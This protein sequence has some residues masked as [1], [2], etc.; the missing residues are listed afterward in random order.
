MSHITFS[1]SSKLASKAAGH[2]LPANGL[3]KASALLGLALLQA[4]ASWA[5]TTTGEQ[6]D[7][8]ARSADAPSQTRFAVDRNHPTWAGAVVNYYY[9]PANQPAALGTDTILNLIQSATRKWQDVCNVTFN[10][11]G[12]TTSVPNIGGSFSDIDRRNVIGWTAFT[13][14]NAGFDGY[15]S[16]WYSGSPA[17]L[18][19]SDMQINTNVASKFVSNPANL[20]ALL[21]HEFGHM[22]AIQ[23]SDRQQAVMF[24]NPYNSYAFQNT[25]RGDDA[26]AC[27]SL[28]GAAPLSDADR[29][30][31]WAE[32]SFPAF[33]A[34]TGT[35]SQEVNGYHYRFFSKTNS[36]L[37]VTGGTLLYYPVGGTVLNLGDVNGYAASAGQDGF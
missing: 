15:T 21:T 6:V 27:A 22:L 30:F 10:Y 8:V 33:F 14:T 25:L 37:A 13:G 4:P 28:Y 12:T 32:Q 5:Q 29:V 19:D 17:K 26:A 3:F 2:F 36:Y 7:Y 20:S 34:P 9:N 35:S 24:A 1:I 16:W 23:H 31:N 11:L 18:V